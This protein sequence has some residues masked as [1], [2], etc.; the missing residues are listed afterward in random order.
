MDGSPRHI[1]HRTVVPCASAITESNG[2]VAN[3][4]ALRDTLVESLRL[5]SLHAINP[6]DISAAKTAFA[7]HRRLSPPTVNAPNSA[8]VA[9]DAVAQR[10]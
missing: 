8:T 4:A 5:L 9:I 7:T 1:R 3:S 10:W 2:T 6:V